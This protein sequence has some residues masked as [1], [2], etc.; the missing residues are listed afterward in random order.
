MK[1]GKALLD[2]EVVQIIRKTAIN[3]QDRYEMEIE[4]GI[5]KGP[6]RFPAA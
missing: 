4:A 5:A 6:I 1:Y 3:I 2:M